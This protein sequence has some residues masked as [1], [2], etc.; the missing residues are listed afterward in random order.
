MALGCS[1]MQ[2]ALCMGLLYAIRCT[3]YAV[4]YALCAVRYALCAVRCAL[5][6]QYERAP[7]AK[8]LGHRRSAAKGKHA[9]VEDGQAA[10]RCGGCGAVVG[11]WWGG[12]G[13]E[14]RRW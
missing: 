10:Q 4:R 7:H 14:V 1:Q 2:V 8:Q 3:L 13:A 6:L 9:A 11:R 12:G 5:C